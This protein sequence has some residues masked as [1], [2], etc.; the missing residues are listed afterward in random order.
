MR[1][2]PTPGC[3]VTVILGSVSF[4]QAVRAG[5]HPAACERDQHERPRHDHQV[6]HARP[7]HQQC[8]VRPRGREQLGQARIAGVEQ[9]RPRQ[10]RDPHPQECLR[11]L[12]TVPVGRIGVSIGALPAVL[13]VNFALV[14]A[15]P[16][17]LT[18]SGTK[19]DAATRHAVV[20]FEADSYAPDGSSGWSVL[21][22]RTCS[23][24]AD[25]GECAA[26][27]P[28]GCV[29]GHS[30]TGSPAASSAST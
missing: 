13:P 2:E 11:L 5:A 26:S 27:P 10:S 30:T 20:A 29:R 12:A 22:Q 14:G 3:E 21:V 23:E 4:V 28:A 24:V 6:H 25:V 18:A 9:R 8:P 19:L 1:V 16:V 15:D 7:G 17:I